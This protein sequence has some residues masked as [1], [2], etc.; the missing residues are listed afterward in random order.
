MFLMPLQLAHVDQNTFWPYFFIFV[1]E[2]SLEFA[3]S[4]RNLPFIMV[5]TAG[6]SDCLQALMSVPY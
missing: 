6:V 4:A 3:L 1:T 2:P 5:Y